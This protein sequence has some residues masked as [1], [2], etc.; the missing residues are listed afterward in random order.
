MI[1]IMK[2]L[3]TKTEDPGWKAFFAVVQMK[4]LLHSEKQLSRV[5]RPIK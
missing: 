1:I 3:K 2:K 4:L 5:L